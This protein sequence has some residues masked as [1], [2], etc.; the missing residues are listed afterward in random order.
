[1]KKFWI[2]S[3][4]FS[5]FFLFSF[6]FGSPCVCHKKERMCSGLLLERGCGNEIQPVDLVATQSL[7][8]ERLD[9]KP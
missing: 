3:L 9:R 2:F 1:M 5:L 6:F 8:E 4:I 7:E